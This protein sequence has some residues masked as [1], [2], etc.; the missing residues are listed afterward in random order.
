MLMLA[1]VEAAIAYAQMRDM[2][3]MALLKHIALS[4]EIFW[5]SVKA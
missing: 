2:Q 3:D 1:Q 4:F 5:D